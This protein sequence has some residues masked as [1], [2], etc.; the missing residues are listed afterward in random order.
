MDQISQEENN[1]RWRLILG[2]LPR[3]D[4]EVSLGQDDQLKD[5]VLEYL[6]PGDG[7]QPSKGRQKVKKWLKDMRQAFKKEGIT[8][9]QKTAID[10]FQ[11]HQ[12]LLEEEFLEQAEPNVHLLAEI[13]QLSALMDD[14]QKALAR[15]MV[16]KIVQE[17][18]RKLRMPMVQKVKSGL[19]RQIHRRQHHQ[20]DI[21]WNKTI[22]AN[23]KNYQKD[24]H[25]IIPEVWRGYQKVQPSLKDVYLL[26]DQ[27]ASMSESVIYSTIIGSILSSVR[28]LST[29]VILFDSDVVD[30]TDQL[31]DIVD[32]LMGLQL[33][34]GTNIGRAL[35]YTRSVIRQPRQSL[36]FL[37][38]DLSD[39]GDA[40]LTRQVFADLLH[41]GVNCYNIVALTDDGH[42]SYDEQSAQFLARMGIPFGYSTPDTFPVL[43]TDMLRN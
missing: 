36:L 39:T 38:S 20:T 25:T 11:I 12:L 40:L 6:F 27:S 30:I 26:I 15:D 29:R 10:K 37:I 19:R 18:E 21:H 7:S 43:L 31:S 42:P 24:F 3:E 16:R 33:A 8:Y 1:R 41:S 4:Q 17:I 34:G 22:L 5:R 23:L 9:L 28:S 2:N 14:H 32:V 13:L 35:A